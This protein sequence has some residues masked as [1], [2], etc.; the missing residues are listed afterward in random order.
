MKKTLLFFFTL[1][2]FYSFSFSRETNRFELYFGTSFSCATPANSS[3][4]SID[5][6]AIAT[7]FTKYS[8]LKNYESQVFEVYRKN[9][10][11]AVWF[12]TNKINELGSLLYKNL[13]NLADD[14]LQITMPYKEKLDVYFTQSSEGSAPD[15][16]LELLMSS[17]YFFYTQH[18]FQGLDD[19]RTTDLGWY[20]P[21]KKQSF[22]SYL[23]T[24][25]QNPN[26]LSHDERKMFKQYYRL[27]DALK[28]HRLIEAKGKWQPIVMMNSNSIG[29]GT[30]SSVVYKIRERLCLLDY[31]KT[32]SKSLKYD[33]ELLQAVWKYKKNM[34]ITVDDLITS[35]LVASLNVPIAD[36]IKSIIFN[37]ERCRWISS[38]FN[39]AEEY[40]FINIPSY[41]MN[42]FKARQVILNS[43]VVVGKVMNQTVIFSGMMQYV[44]FSP[45]WNVPKSI[46]DKEITPAIKKNKNYL[47]QHNM[48]WN[49]GNIRQKPGPKNSLGLVKFLF[50]NSNS[51]Y[52]HDTPSKS[53]FKEEKRAFSHGC[54]RLEKP[55]ELAYLLVKDDKNWTMEKLNNAFHSDKE[56]WYTLK[57]KIPVYIGYF[58]S[59]VNEND[60]VQ[61][62][63]DVY[64]RD[65]CLTP[66]LYSEQ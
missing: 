64:A 54:I 33:K 25:T 35:R 53:L 23:D 52:L 22:V 20:I 43:K 8:K 3:E 56:I 15:V 48:E 55:I 61:F 27:R 24:L 34:G 37:M 58:T 45:Y 65:E 47:A 1:V 39:Q 9:H 26:L 10:N 36:R 17:A 60:E 21:R 42:Y 14:G 38:D 28:K 66:Y 46:I 6:L 41:E 7:F 44:V 62:Y 2:S 5:S 40:I 18:V 59:W 51:I 16:E 11:Q 63:D 29:V 31:L 50:P 4:I 12:P 19:K 49:D 32:N 30:S 13:G 57:N